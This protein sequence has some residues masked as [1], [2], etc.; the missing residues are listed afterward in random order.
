V[1]VATKWP[2]RFNRRSR[3][4]I[5]CRYGGTG[6]IKFIGARREKKSFGRSDSPLLSADPG[7]I[8]AGACRPPLIGGTVRRAL[9]DKEQGTGATES[10]RSQRRCA[11]AHRLRWRT[12]DAAA[13]PTKHR[14]KAAGR[15]ARNA[16]P[17]MACWTS[18][19]CCWKIFCRAAKWC[20]LT[21]R[22]GEEHF[23]I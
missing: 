2:N 9:L 7:Y 17:A 21:R 18:R 14:W 23:K 6:H 4:R 1:C 19:R 13:R 5:F 15:A 16:E 8:P 12:E 22:G 10:I 11:D 3:G 20:A